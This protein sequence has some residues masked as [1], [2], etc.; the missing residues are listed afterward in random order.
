MRAASLKAK[1]KKHR[2]VTFVGRY[3]VTVLTDQRI[4]LPADVIR[5]LK[6]H[7][8]ERVFIGRLPGSKALVLCPENLWGCWIKKI[9]KSFPCLRTHVGSRSFLIPWQTIRWDNKGRIT[10]PRRAR[11][12]ACIKANETAIIMG[13]DYRFELW[14]EKEYDEIINECESALHKSVRY[15]LSIENIVSPPKKRKSN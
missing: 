2:P 15:P 10:L 3:E 4:I 1:K 5:Q 11:E 14:S 13:T 7:S 12:Y 6:N 8:I 9:K